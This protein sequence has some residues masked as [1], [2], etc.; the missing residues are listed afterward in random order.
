MSAQDIEIHSKT[1]VNQ[2]VVTSLKINLQR[3]QTAMQDTR[4]GQQT[5]NTTELLW[6]NNHTRAEI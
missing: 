4:P 6:L 1:R 3:S 5:F 2:S